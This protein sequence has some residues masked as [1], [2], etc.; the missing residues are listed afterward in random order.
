[1]KRFS[2]NFLAFSFALMF[3][4]PAHADLKRFVHVA[5]G[6]FRAD[7]PD[8]QEDYQTL[9]DLGVKTIINLRNE[10]SWQKK[11][12]K[13]ASAMGFEYRRYP[14]NAWQYPSDKY[15]N[16]I[17]DD[18]TNPNLQPVFVHCQHG[19]DRTGLIVGLYRVRFEKWKPSDAYAEMRSLGFDP[20][21]VPLWIYFRNKTGGKNSDRADSSSK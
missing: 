13:I 17:L 14:M 2:V 7:Q 9:K 15:V 6:I 16:A 20:K 18:L 19:K 10:S 11:E 21:N 3:N 12:A 8:T 1:M 5:P 4:A